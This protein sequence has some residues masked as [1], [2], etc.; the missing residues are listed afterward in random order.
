V[1]GFTYGV[2]VGG[3]GDIVTKME[4][5]YASQLGIEAVGVKDQVTSNT[6]V[7]NV[8]G[9]GDGGSG[10]TIRD[11]HVLNNSGGGLDVYGTGALVSG[12]I[13]NGNGGQGVA[14]SAAGFPLPT[15][16]GNT[17]NNNAELGIL[18]NPEVIDGGKNTAQGNGTRAQCQDVVCS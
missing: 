15:V 14:L 4:V 18:G 5:A 6:A 17:A 16:T 11:N 7:E 2:A 13:A 10:D 1:F 3:T 8:Y 9:L 12:N